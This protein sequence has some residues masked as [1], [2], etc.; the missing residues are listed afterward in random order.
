[1][2]SKRDFVTADAVSLVVVRDDDSLRCTFI[3]AA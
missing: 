2:S 3:I 1:V